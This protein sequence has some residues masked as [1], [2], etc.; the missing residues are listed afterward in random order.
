MIHHFANPYLSNLHTARQTWTRIAIQDRARA[1]PFPPSLEQGVLL[2]MQTETRIER[3]ADLVRSIAP[4]TAAGI[5]VDE[6]ARGAIVAGA[7]HAVLANEDATDASLHAIAAVGTELGELHEVGV[8]SW[9]EARF[10]GEVER[11]EGTVEVWQAGSGVEEAEL[12]AV[13]EGG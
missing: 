10:V 3:R 8:P 11:A 9:A 2:G 7:Y 1:N 5:A 4:L 6:A 13:E 12:G